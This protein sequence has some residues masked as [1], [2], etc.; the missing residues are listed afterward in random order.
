MS[1]KSDIANVRDFL[2]EVY[3]N[4]RMGIIDPFTF[5]AVISGIKDHLPES[6]SIAEFH[7]I[8]L[9]MDEKDDKWRRSA[10]KWAIAKMQ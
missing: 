5:D 2:D 10:Q 6:V 9:E 3:R 4:A 1:D 8:L 7:A